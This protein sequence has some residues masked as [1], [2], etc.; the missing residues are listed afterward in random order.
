MNRIEV[1]GQGLSGGLI[2]GEASLVSDV[3]DVEHDISALFAAAKLRYQQ[4]AK[5]Q[6]LSMEARDVAL[7]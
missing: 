4:Y 7:V 2:T 5:D 3:T 1:T 6:T